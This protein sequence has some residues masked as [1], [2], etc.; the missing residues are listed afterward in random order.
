M[1]SWKIMHNATV[2]SVWI[3]VA[4][5]AFIVEALALVATLSAPMS[6]YRSTIDTYRL[7]S[8]SF[9]P[10]CSGLLLE[11]GHLVRRC[12][13]LP[14]LW[15]SWTSLRTRPQHWCGNLRG[16]V[17]SR[18]S[19]AS[20][21]W[22]FLPSPQRGFSTR[23]R[24][25]CPAWLSLTDLLSMLSPTPL[26]P[27]LH[28]FHVFMATHMSLSA[29]P[30]LHLPLR[31]WA[32][33]LEPSGHRL[34]CPATGCR[35][36]RR[37]LCQPLLAALVGTGSVC[38]LHPCPFSPCTLARLKQA[39]RKVVLVVVLVVHLLELMSCCVGRQWQQ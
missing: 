12:A 15:R 10:L 17:L 32:C 30:L 14:S 7:H 33:F 24:R 3:L 27:S 37:W 16:P 31:F 34:R 29:S 9:S 18:F 25:G 26:S 5:R 4:I 22:G 21:G 35:T 28:V 19:T 39:A 1:E 11:R 36:R 8:L 13:Q 6:H 20:L 23:S 38:S 2:W